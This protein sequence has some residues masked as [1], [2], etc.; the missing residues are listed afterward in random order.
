MV[1]EENVTPIGVATIAVA[2]ARDV[3]SWVPDGDLNMVD[4]L[5]PSLC[6]TVS[7]LDENPAAA[8]RPGRA[9]EPAGTTWTPTPRIPVRLES[10]PD[11]VSANIDDQGVIEP[12]RRHDY[13]IE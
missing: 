8:Q 2:P 6:S 3:R 1:P 5:L 4:Q 7:R 13:G 12:I 9:P 10:T 11:D